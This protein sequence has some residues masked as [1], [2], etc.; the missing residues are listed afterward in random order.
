MAVKIVVKI[1]GKRELIVRQVI[2]NKRHEMELAQNAC[3]GF[4]THG[5]YEKDPEDEDFDTL[6]ISKASGETGVTDVPFKAVSDF[7]L[8]GFHHSESMR[9]CGIKFGELSSDQKSDLIAFLQNQTTHDQPIDRRT[10][11]NRR[12]L[13]A[14]RYS[15]SER[16]KDGDRRKTALIKGK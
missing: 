1:K 5:I 3:A 11:N 14:S 2:N 8:S 7:C 13:D 15:S 12:K 9:K 6:T 10:I 4:C 16:R